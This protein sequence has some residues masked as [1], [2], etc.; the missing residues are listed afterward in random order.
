MA[1]HAW[2]HGSLLQ[3]QAAIWASKGRE[4]TPGS[5]GL[6][7]PELHPTIPFHLLILLCACSAVNNKP[8]QRKQFYYWSSRRSSDPGVTWKMQ[9]V[10]RCCP[11]LDWTGQFLCPWP[12]V[13]R[14]ARS[15]PPFPPLHTS[16]HLHSLPNLSFVLSTM[17]LWMVHREFVSSIGL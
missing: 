14:G 16:T 7:T 17:E 15:E 4:R 2:E 3:S 6:W 8:Q 10:V 11:P 5:L 12:L 1:F 13:G 9:S